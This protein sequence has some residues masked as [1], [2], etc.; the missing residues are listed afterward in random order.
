MIRPV[1]N[2]LTV[3][4]RLSIR[5]YRVAISPLLPRTCRFYPT[6]SRYAME[7][8]ARHGPVRGCYLAVR[9]LL[10]CH[11]WHPGGVDPVPPTEADECSSNCRE[12]HS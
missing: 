4:L 8:V 11:P 6:C 1:A 10:R 12:S 2:C 7:A 9:R 5:V 3:V